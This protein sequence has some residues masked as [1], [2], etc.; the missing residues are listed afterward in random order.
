MAKTKKQKEIVC[1]SCGHDKLDVVKSILCD[2]IT[3]YKCRKCK[4]LTEVNEVDKWTIK[5]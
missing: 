2:A 3:V 1:E 5:L 4:E